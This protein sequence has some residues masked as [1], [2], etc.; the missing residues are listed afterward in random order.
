MKTR[1]WMLDTGYWMLDAR[2]W[3]LVAGCWMLA[4]LPAGRAQEKVIQP[5][6]VEQILTGTNRTRFISPWGAAQAGL[7]TNAVAY[8]NATAGA[9]TNDMPGVITGLRIGTN[10]LNLVKTTETRHVSLSNAATFYL[11]DDDYGSWKVYVNGNVFTVSNTIIGAVYTFSETGVLLAS[12]IS[13]GGETRTN[14]P[15]GTTYTNSRT[16]DQQAGIIIGASI[17]TNAAAA[18]LSGTVPNA[19]L[20]DTLT[21]K[22]I[23]LDDGQAKTIGGPE[24]SINIDEDVN[25]IAFVGAAPFMNGA[26]TTNLNATTAFGSGTVPEARLPKILTNIYSVTNATGSNVVIGNGQIWIT[27]SISPTN[28]SAVSTNAT[29]ITQNVFAQTNGANRVVITNGDLTTTGTLTVGGS[30]TAT[31]P[32]IEYATG[33]GTLIISNTARGA[34][35]THGTASQLIIGT[36]G[37]I[38]IGVSAPNVNYSLDAG[39]GIRALALEATATLPSITFTDGSSL[40]EDY[41]IVVNTNHFMIL[42]KD[43]NRVDL[44]I[45]G[46]GAASFGGS[47]TATQGVYEVEWPWAGPTNEISVLSNYTYEVT[48]DVSVTNLLGSVVG[49]R[50]GCALILTNS[51]ATNYT[52]SL[53]AANVFTTDGAKQWTITNG[54]AAIFSASGGTLKYAGFSPLKLP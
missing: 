31:N 52:L 17:G 44:R 53:T 43:D 36:N 51:T 32:A 38:G 28:Q 20:A 18:N 11:S 7:G 42:N 25:S 23:W 9:G 5:A 3:W 35:L 26:N 12:S 16:T 21:N 1:C 41:S 33:G 14:W 54:Q 8:T 49:L 29:R 30:I 24:L 34:V 15:A 19:R 2:Y 47:L 4:A 39:A 46:N 48:G 13:L 22:S 45:D 10:T 50:A 27:N 40:E 6:T 37:S